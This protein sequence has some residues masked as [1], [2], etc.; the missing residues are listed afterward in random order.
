MTKL[1][2]IDAGGATIRYA[3]WDNNAHE[4]TKQGMVTT[5]K[6]LNAYYAV[7]SKIVRTYQLSN[8]VV[9]VGIST[10]GAVNKATGIIEGA[11]AIPYIHN[12]EIQGELEKRFGLPVMM[13]N[14]I[15]CAALA[16]LKCGAAQ[17]LRN[18][19]YMA[20]DADVGGA[21]IIDGHIQHGAHLLSGEFGAILMADGRPLNAVGTIAHLTHQYNQKAHAQLT[22]AEVFALARQGD[23]L[24]HQL[25]TDLYRYLAQA[26]YNLQ[27]S[28]DPD[29]I[30][31]GGALAQIDFLVPNIEL[32]RQPLLTQ[33]KIAPLATPLLISQ[34]HSEANLIGALV[35][36]QQRYPQ[37]ML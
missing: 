30:I 23:L 9:G 13:E 20:I 17:G 6:S 4:L 37:K 3:L 24:A 32:E 19:L 15:N 10:P 25:T 1:A 2:L 31:L 8:Q 16:E 5:P 29:A 7:L 26:V 35:D 18:V 27:Y 28:F 34:Y 21:V 33:G 11:S 12:F 36:F 22:G 14:E